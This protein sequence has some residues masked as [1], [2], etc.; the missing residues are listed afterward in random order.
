MTDENDEIQ[1]PIE[2]GEDAQEPSIEPKEEDL[3]ETASSTKDATDYREK[4]LLELADKENMRKRL[5]REQTEA[6]R[7]ASE[8]SA[9]DIL[10]PLDQF[11]NALKFASEMSDEVRNWAVGFE[12]IFSQ[13]K[14]WLTR[15]GITSYSSKG[16]IFTPL[17][18]EAVERIVDNKL[19]EGTI[20]REFTRGY[21]GRQRVIRPARVAVCVHVKDEDPQHSESKSSPIS[22]D[23]LQVQ[24]TDSSTNNNHQE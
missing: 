16:E 14:E 13:F 23:P 2:Q 1:S 6:I 15:Q 21:R 22:Q 5:L 10:A 7:L 24:T 8:R 11:E 17:L 4:Y 19:Q 20:L 3:C 9:L 12:M 18:H